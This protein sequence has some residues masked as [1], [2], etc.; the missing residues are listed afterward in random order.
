MPVPAAPIPALTDDQRKE[1]ETIVRKRTNPQHLVERARIILSAAEGRG[2]AA[3]A[4]RLRLTE[5]TVSKWRKRWTNWQTAEAAVAERLADAPRSG[6]PARI[7]PEQICRIIAMSC[8]PP[9]K[10][11]RPITHWTQQELADEAVRQGI[12]DVVSQRSV[13]RFLKSG[14][15]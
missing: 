5:S 9:S 6:A 13:G 15:P 8:E 10:Y 1:L 2:I 12:V 11:D 4:R 14:R 3:T 7:T